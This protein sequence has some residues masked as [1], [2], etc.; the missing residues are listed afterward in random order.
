MEE[1]DFVVVGGGPGG[2]VTASRLTEDPA[3]S[4]V[5]IEAGPDRRGFLGT[6][7]A[8]GAIVL[9]PKKSSN[10]WGLETVP[11]P[12]LNHRR[13]YHILGRGLGG[14]TSINTLMYMR[15]NAKDYDGWAALGNPGWS[16]DE[17]LPY[18]RK[19][20]SNQTHRN[21]FH[22]NDGPLWVEELRTDNPYHG[23]IKE[24]CAEAGWPHT[25]PSPPR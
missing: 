25:A 10:N 9:G 13:D 7:A 8:A 12:G 21:E 4:A 22:G 11:D 17:V 6:C 20:E 19:S 2:C 18:F 1:Y 24:A 15:G 3:V 14:G 16:Y 5:L 23:I